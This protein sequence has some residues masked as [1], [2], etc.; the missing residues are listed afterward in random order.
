MTHSGPCGHGSPSSPRP[1]I[2]WGTTDSSSPA[3]VAIA[4]M[5]SASRR[6]MRRT[7]SP[8]APISRSTA[9]SPRRRT[10]AATRLLPTPSST[11]PNSAK[12]TTWLTHWSDAGA[13]APRAAAPG[14]AR[15]PGRWAAQP[16][17]EAPPPEVNTASYWRVVVWRVIRS[18]DAMTLPKPK[19]R[20]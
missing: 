16:C 19:P 11:Y 15:R 20:R 6:I 17:T 3:P 5:M 13:P 8:V 18:V 7:W 4:V 9:N 1:R 14:S 12:E 10:V 2:D